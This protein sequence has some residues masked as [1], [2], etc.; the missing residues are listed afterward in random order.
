[1]LV[2][3]RLTGLSALETYYAGVR[4]RAQFGPHLP[5]GRRQT[6]AR[7]WVQRLEGRNLTPKSGAARPPGCALSQ[8]VL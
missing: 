5:R 8:S 2:A 7:A 6:G 4:A 1:M 3:C